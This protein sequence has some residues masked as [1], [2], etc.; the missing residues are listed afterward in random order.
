MRN[1]HAVF[2]KKI[3]T[4]FKLLV[5]FLIKVSYEYFYTIAEEAEEQARNLL[6][7]YQFIKFSISS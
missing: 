7:C 6:P 5:N 3:K 2:E 1:T 4:C